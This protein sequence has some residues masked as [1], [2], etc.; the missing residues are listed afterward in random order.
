MP[1]LPVAVVSPRDT[2]EVQRIV[3]VCAR[4]DVPITVTAGR[5]GVSG[6][7][8][9]MFG[10]VVL[11]MT[12]MSGV[13]SV[14]NTSG[15]V[16]VLPGT[17]G[18]DLEQALA[19]HNLTVG[20]FP[21]SFDISTV[22]GWIACLGA[23]QFSTR[24]GKINEMIVGLEIVL[25]DGSVISTGGAPAA[26]HG[27]DASSLFVGSEGTLGVVTRAWLRAH[28]VAPVR[29]KSA[30]FFPSFADG[31]KAMREAIR[32]H[33]T[34]AVLRLYDAVEAQRSHGGD[35]ANSTLI[36]LDDGELEIVDA[37]LAVVDRC[38]RAHGATAA[39]VERVD[40]WLA[41]RNDTSGLQ[42][43]TKKGFV[44]DTMEVAAPWS[45]IGA[46][47]QGVLE[48]TRSVDGARSVSAHVSHSYLD[49]A[50]IYFTFVGQISSRDIND[51]TTA[52]HQALYVAMWNAAQRAALAAGG[53][54]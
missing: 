50:C 37:T 2:A 13:V 41:H 7:S 10:G 54:L 20:H 52:E 17:F 43:L 27:P 1:Q 32:A 18:P 24:Y 53:N 33:A 4:R 49:G 36:V 31:V 23:G 47:Y 5:S 34:P 21:Q 44:I 35:G 28:D 19:Q 29:K 38:A 3:T 46:V 30:Y 9:P 45:K 12:A 6:A 48:A 39:P 26:A 14:D 8:V 51:A 22:G 25:A 42:A 16:E 11:D 40:H 15:V